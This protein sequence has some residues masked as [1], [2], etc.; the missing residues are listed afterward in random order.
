MKNSDNPFME[1][2]IG[3]LMGEKKVD[4]EKTNTA[5]INFA[6]EIKRSLGEDIKATQSLMVEEKKESKFFKF[7]QKIAQSLS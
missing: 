1:G 2:Q 7:M 4:E 5:K 3:R 6:E